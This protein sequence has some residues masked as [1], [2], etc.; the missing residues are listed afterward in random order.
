VLAE[1]TNNPEFLPRVDAHRL[2]LFVAFDELSLLDF[3]GPQTVFWSASRIME[4]RGL[5]GYVRPVA[6]LRGGLVNTAEN[7]A[8]ETSQLSAY[9]D[10]AIDT[11]V[12]PGTPHI[13]RLLP[14]LTD[15]S[16]WLRRAAHRAR[17]TVSVC[18]GAFLLARA[19][20]LDG[21]RAATH[22]SMCDTL[23]DG[24][25][26]V[27]VDRDAI[28]VDE[29]PVWTSA[30]VTAG[31]DLALALVEA[32]CGRDVAM[33]AAREMVVFLKRPGGQ[34]QFS[35]LLQS[36]TNASEPFDELHRWIVDNIGDA[37]LTVEGLA[38]RVGM[39]PRNF[40]RVYRQRTGSTPAKA[41]EAFRLDAAR[42]LLEDSSYNIDQVAR[43][44]GFGS[45][46]RMRVAFLR[47]LSVTPR[48]YRRRF[49]RAS[50]AA[51]SETTG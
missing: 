28:F 25:P 6:S 49:A 44:C 19:G 7:V 50:S 40:A 14:Q 47:N 20:L 34:S 33:T 29:S 11:I 5:P 37:G 21:R 46:E 18:T 39:S 22:W 2:V 9:D 41:V 17:R 15:L 10:D 1:M 12:V 26:S 27:E 4:A 38:A 32:D 30:G 51:G 16:D 8:I 42:R 13:E 43:E 23:R 31:I 48:D 24:F 35:Q 36:Q 3:T 45:D